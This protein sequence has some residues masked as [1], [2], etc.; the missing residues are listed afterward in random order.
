MTPHTKSKRRD[1]CFFSRKEMASRYT[2]DIHC[3]VIS[4]RFSHTHSEYSNME[5]H[6]HAKHCLTRENITRLEESV[7]CI[8]VIHV[9][10][11]LH[12]TA[13]NDTKSSEMV[14][15]Y[16]CSTPIHDA[17]NVVGVD[18]AC[19]EIFTTMFIMPV[20]FLLCNSLFQVKFSF[21]DFLEMDKNRY[22]FTRL[23]NVA[24]SIFVR[25]IQDEQTKHYNRKQMIILNDWSNLLVLT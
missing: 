2:H 24:K 16:K 15:Y 18:C 17:L 5:E 6:S 1:N 14:L 8:T 9:L 20:S 19:V 4:V 3:C 13:S 22:S 23:L 25:K 21:H 10:C 12:G 11:V 7:L